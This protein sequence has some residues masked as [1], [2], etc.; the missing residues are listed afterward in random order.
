MLQGSHRDAGRGDPVGPPRVQGD[1]VTELASC[2]SLMLAPTVVTSA[3][4]P[5]PGLQGSQLEA[6]AGSAEG[7]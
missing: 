6:R 2:P 1:I 5:G 4:L 7:S 3:T